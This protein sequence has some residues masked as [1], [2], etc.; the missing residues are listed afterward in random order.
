MA[1]SPL[2]RPLV[3]DRDDV[4]R[5]LGHDGVDHRMLAT[6]G[7]ERQ[8]GALDLQ[9]SHQ[10]RDRR[11]LVAL[12]RRLDL[13]QHE[14][15]RVVPGRDQ[16]RHARAPAMRAAQALAVDGDQ[17]ARQRGAQVLHPAHEEAL[18]LMRVEQAEDAPEGVVRGDA[19]GVR[20]MLAQPVDLQLGPVGDRDPA[21]GTTAD[22]AQR[23]EHQLVQRKRTRPRARIV[24]F[25]QR[26]DEVGGQRRSGHRGRRRFELR[27]SGQ[28]GAFIT[29]NRPGSSCNRPAA[30]SD[31]RWFY[32]IALVVRAL[33]ELGHSH[34]LLISSIFYEIANLL[35]QNSGI[36]DRGYSGNGCR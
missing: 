8:D 29:R 16:M 19:V 30:D 14:T 3:L 25:G 18:E 4:V 21:V 34:T 1:A 9:G 10:F 20:Q 7:I 5:G 32:E 26:L 12:G 35:S 15:A 33:F 31:W 11:D 2:A 27:R 22:A 6:H 13:T 36:L 23:R 28:R 17:L 24:Q